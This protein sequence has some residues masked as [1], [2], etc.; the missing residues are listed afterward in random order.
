MMK[1]P[2]QNEMG[3]AKGGKPANHNIVR[4]S[5]KATKEGMR[6]L[7]SFS[8]SFKRA[9]KPAGSQHRLSMRMKSC[10]FA[11]TVPD[12]WKTMAPKSADWLS[13]P[14]FRRKPNMNNP[15]MQKASHAATP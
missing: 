13:R 7:P 11:A 12:S 10:A 2:K 9:Q 4:Q 6:S 3:S 1:K 14:I 5:A 15:A 8:Q